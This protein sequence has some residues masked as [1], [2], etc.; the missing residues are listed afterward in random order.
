MRAASLLCYNH[1]MQ[2]TDVLRLYNDLK[3][4]DISVWID[5]GWCIDSL[6]G[7]QTRG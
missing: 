4:N 2:A 6:L 7:K 1:A 5:G 3:A